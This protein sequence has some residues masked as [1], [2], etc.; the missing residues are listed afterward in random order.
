MSLPFS[1]LHSPCSP[2]LPRL[3][4]SVFIPFLPAFSSFTVPLLFA[5]FPPIFPFLSFLPSLPDLPSRPCSLPPSPLFT[6]HSP[7]SLVLL[8]LF[9]PAYSFPSP[10]RHASGAEGS[11]GSGSCSRS[12][13]ETRF[14]PLLCLISLLYSP[15]PPPFSSPTSPHLL[16]VFPP[17][18]PFLSFVPSL[19]LPFL[20]SP[21][22]PS[23]GAH[24]DCSTPFDFFL[25]WHSMRLGVKACHSLHLCMIPGLQTSPV[26]VQT[27]RPRS[28]PAG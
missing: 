19:S 8:P 24:C 27:S 22:L 13:Q 11:P 5:V 1:S 15:R 20:L 14:S 3:I 7:A 4:P 2:L 28:K 23:L 10:G 18:S 6:L 21:S 16:V 26:G 12:C 17:I 9:S 25:P